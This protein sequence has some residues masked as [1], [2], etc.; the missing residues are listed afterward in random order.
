MRIVPAAGLDP[1]AGRGRCRRAPARSSKPRRR[2][3]RSSSGCNV[4][5]AN[6][7]ITW[8]DDRKR[9][10]V[11]IERSLAPKLAAI[12]D[13]RVNFQSQSGGG[14]EGGGG[15]GRDITL[16]LGGDDPDVLLATA[17]KIAAEMEDRPG[18]PSRRASQ[19]DLVAARDHHPAAARPCRRSRRDD[20]RARARRS[21]SRRSATSTRT[22]PNSRCPIARCRSAW[23]CPKIGAPR[24]CDAREFAGADPERRLGAAESRSPRSASAPARRRSSAPIRCAASRSAPISRP[25]LVS[26]DAWTKINAL[27]TM[28]NLPQGVSELQLGDSKWQA[29]IDVQ[30]RHRGGRRHPAGVRGAGAALQAG[31]VAVR[32]HGLAA[33]RAARRGDSPCG[34][35]APPI[36]LPVFIGLLMLLGIVAKNSI[37]LVDFAVEEMDQA[38]T[39]TRRSSRP[40]TSAPSR[41]S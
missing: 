15:G 34:S 14:P 6:L 22:A 35:P 30:L 27:P 10:S 24:S 25:G 9:T 26:S 17:N 31:P 11:E 21:A 39:R 18:T 16:H 12:P 29:E 40:G 36:S 38:S 5:S 33:A 2:S 41:S 23:R 13:A 7:N 4:G 28:K 1:R 37:L 19:G 3:S 8:S 20:Q 32:Q